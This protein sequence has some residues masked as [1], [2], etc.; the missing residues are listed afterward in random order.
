MRNFSWLAVIALAVG[1]R[2]GADAG[3]GFNGRQ[4]GDGLNAVLADE[5]YDCDGVSGCFLYTV[6]RHKNA[7]AERYADAPVQE[8]LLHFSGER[9]A[10]V[11]A[12]FAERDFVRV[13]RS[14]TARLGEGEVQPHGQRAASSEQFSD[15]IYLWRQRG[16]LVRAQ[17]FHVGAARSSLIISERSFLSE[18]VKSD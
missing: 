9:L 2:A 17:R 10:A 5:R 8:L 18:L 3:V 7:A 6:C 11:E 14:L 16:N 13:V 12:Y 4:L 15:V 1:L